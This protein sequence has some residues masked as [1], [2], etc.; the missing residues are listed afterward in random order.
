MLPTLCTA[1]KRAGGDALVLRTGES[2][3]VLTASGRQNV[4][5][6]VLS[7]NALEALVAQIFTGDG[8]QTL[9]DTGS[10]VEQVTVPEAGLTLSAR[11]ERTTNQVTIELRERRA[12]ADRRRT[13]NRTVRADT[14]GRR[15]R[16]G[17][18]RARDR[19]LPRSAA[20]V[21]RAALE[22][23]RRRVRRGAGVCLH[24]RCRRHP[25]RARPRDCRA[26]NRTLQRAAG[27]ALRRALPAGA[28]RRVGRRRDAA[29]FECHGCRRDPRARTRGVDVRRSTRSNI[30]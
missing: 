29:R 2:P 25:R 3:H 23:S 18:R 5:R 12:G 28:V 6:A 16:R 20:V 10:V 26:R 15:G 21:R 4:A 11:A 13:A 19:S 22:W 8:R 24:E 1:M 9:H 30:R 17:R 14:R 7:A 27:R